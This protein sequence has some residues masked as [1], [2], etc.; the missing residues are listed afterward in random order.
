MAKLFVSPRAVE[1]LDNIRDYIKNELKSSQAA[2][3]TV[4]KI[5]SNYEQLALFPELGA[6]LK[7][8]D[9]SLQRYRHLVVGSHVVF[10][11]IEG[12]NIYI[13]RILHSQ[14]DFLKTLLQ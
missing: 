5:I 1:D 10:Y 11:R 8:I 14:M 13:I 12:G 3:N 2:K 6:S 9:E 4:L 7:T